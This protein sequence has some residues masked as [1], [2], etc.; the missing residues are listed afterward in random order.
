MKRA[1]FYILIGGATSISLLVVLIALIIISPTLSKKSRQALPD[2]DFHIKKTIP[3]DSFAS[4]TIKD[5]TLKELEKSKELEV[6]I[7][8]KECNF[9]H[10]S[11]MVMCT[12]VTCTLFDHKNISASLKTDKAFVNRTQ[13]AIFL[14][15]SV[16]GHMKDLIIHGSDIYYNFLQQ[17]LTTDKS[18][19]YTHPDFSLCSH[20]SFIDLKNNRIEMSNGVVSEFTM[21]DKQQQP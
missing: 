20:Q 1:N 7:N 21:H 9:I 19:M 14:S 6:I 2:I 12:H 11:D 17:T 4:I 8:A 16:L 3:Q 15:G 10:T 18:I 13:K 5:F